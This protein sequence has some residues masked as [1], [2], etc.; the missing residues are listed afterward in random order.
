ME[1]KIIKINLNEFLLDNPD[2]SNFGKLNLD[3]LGGKNSKEL[4]KKEEKELKSE[5]KEKSQRE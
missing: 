5:K 4:S 2:F 3:F 1:D